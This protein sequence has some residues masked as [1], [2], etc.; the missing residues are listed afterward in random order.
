MAACA[1]RGNGQALLKKPDAVKT[2]LIILRDVGLR[3]DPRL[4]DF[5]AFA[6]T[7]SAKPR[8]V[9]GGDGRLQIRWRQDVV[10]SVAELAAGRVGIVLRRLPAV[11]AG[12]VL[13]LLIGV[14]R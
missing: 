8:D 6:M 13:G 14:A 12:C 1:N 9:D 4:A 2:V 11:N 5:G 10:G 3:H 7:G